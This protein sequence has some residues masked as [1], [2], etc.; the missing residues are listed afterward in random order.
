[1][2]F[3]PLHAADLSVVEKWMATNSGVSSVKIS[4]AQ[5][6]TMRSIKVPIRQNGTLWMDYGRNRF[7]WET[8]IPTQTIVT[9][10]GSKLLIMRPI[11]KKYERRPFGSGGDNQG[12]SVM[13]GG[14]PRSMSEFKRKYRVISTEKRNNTYRIVTQPLGSSGK[15]VSQFTFVVQASGYRMLGIEIDL[16]DG[17]SINTVFNRVELN[18]SVPSSLFSPDLTGYKETKF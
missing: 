4:F 8:G 13:A 1:M 12:M 10:Q 17:S 15:G 3:S 5:T 18:A 2:V 16:K 11:G 6:R 9:K 14:F 7:R